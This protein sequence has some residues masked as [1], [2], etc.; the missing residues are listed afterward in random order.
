MIKC[1]GSYKPLK[2]SK[3]DVLLIQWQSH[4]PEVT[5]GG[6]INHC[7]GSRAFKAL[8]CILYSLLGLHQILHL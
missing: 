4:R 1:E 7:L 2:R 5:N 6:L 3:K 8:H